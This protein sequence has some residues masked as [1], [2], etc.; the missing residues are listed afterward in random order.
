MTNKH[1]T[2]IIALAAFAGLSIA[3]F[4]GPAPATK[5]HEKAPEANPLSFANGLVTID[6]QERI[7]WEIRD[8]NF[9]FNDAVNALTDDNWGLQKARIGIKV[10]P[11]SWLTLYAQGQDS[12]EFGSDRADFPGLLGA[13]GDDP[14]DLRQAYIEISD[15]T[16]CPWGVKIGRQ[17]LS[18]GDERLIGAFEWNNIGRVFDAVKLTY[19]SGPWTIDAFASSVV[20][21]T[22]SGMNMS[23]LFNGNETRREQIFSGIY[24]STTAWG[25]QTTDLFVL[26]LHEE[27]AVTSTNFLTIGTRIKSKPGAFASAPASDGKTIAAPKPVGFDYEFEGAFQ[28][29]EVKGL[30]LTAFALHGGVG[31]TF[32]TEWMPR[33]GVSY[34]YGSGDN[35]PADGDIETFQNLFPTNHKFYGQM[36]AF[37]WQNVQ[38]LELSVK[39]T[40]TKKLNARVAVHAFWLAS[41]DDSWYR[42]NG[43]TTVRPLTPAARAAGSYIGTEADLTLT[44]ALSKNVN[45]EGGYSHFFAGDYLADTGASDDA[46][47]GYIQTTISF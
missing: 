37:S 31:Y 33:V 40:P 26:H 28:T 27:Q 21:P 12:R 1:N 6:I 24:A 44:Y 38:D 35:N 42:A 3:A 18:F 4:A 46:N 13:E 41:N 14:F 16:Q 15:F 30:D 45:I 20:Q 43:V 23:D 17:L 11:T 7:R 25:P 5:A 10:K 29:G 22:R 47:F 9:D 36:D 2:P 32:D 8:N 19:K 34:D 39:F